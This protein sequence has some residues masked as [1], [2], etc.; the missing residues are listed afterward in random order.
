MKALKAGALKL[1]GE[2]MMNGEDLIEDEAKKGLQHLDDSQRM[3]EAI[4][5]EELSISIEAKLA[6]FKAK[7]IKKFGAQEVFGKPET[8]EQILG[9]FR[10]TYQLTVKEYGEVSA[11]SIIYGSNLALELC[12]PYCTIEAW[13]LLKRLVAI[14][15][16]LNGQEHPDT[17]DLK[18]TLFDCKIVCLGLRGHGPKLFEVLRHEADNKYVVRGPR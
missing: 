18:H 16:Q 10:V 7:C 6:R 2:I 13:R 14:S 4:G 8:Q 11:N 5:D 15:K 3:S 17:K 12:K 1:T 9:R